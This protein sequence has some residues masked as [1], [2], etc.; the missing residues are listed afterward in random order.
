MRFFKVKGEISELIPLSSFTE[1][2]LPLF[3]TPIRGGFPSPAED[4]IATRLDLN[5]ELI[6]H[7]EKTFLGRAASDSMEPDIC[8]GEMLVID[9]EVE[10]RSGNIIVAELC[11]EFC[12]KELRKSADGALL[13]LSRNPS[14]EPIVV[15]E[16]MRFVPRGR[17][18]YSI[19]RF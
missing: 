3:A 14:Y 1:I 6:K 16:E 2:K 15:T 4:Y 19:K 17:V 13:L 8:E 9:S 18:M 11:G 10:I 7:P 5:K 12:M